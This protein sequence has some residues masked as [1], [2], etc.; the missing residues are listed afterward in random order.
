[1]PDS[2]SRLLAF[3]LLNISNF[4]NAHSCVNTLPPQREPTCGWM[5][6]RVLAPPVHQSLNSRFDN[7]VFHKD[8]IFFSGRRRSRRQRDDC[9]DFVN[10]KIRWISSSTQSLGDTH[11]GRMYVRAFIRVSVCAY[12]WTPLIVLC[13]VKKITTT[14]LSKQWCFPISYQL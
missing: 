13:F 4:W 11:R 8:E 12:M 3:N 9:G 14:K 7:L 1:M 5:V 2:F 6:R 10:L